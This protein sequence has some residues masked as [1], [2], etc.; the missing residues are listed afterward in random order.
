MNFNFPTK[1]YLASK[2][3][4]QQASTSPGA[5]AHWY[6]P[7][8]LRNMQKCSIVQVCGNFRTKLEGELWRTHQDN[9]GRFVADGVLLAC[10]TL[11]TIVSESYQE[12]ADCSWDGKGC[13]PT[14]FDTGVH[15]SN[16]VQGVGGI[17]LH[18]GCLHQMMHDITSIFNFL[19]ILHILSNLIRRL[20]I[21]GQK[22]EVTAGWR[23]LHSREPHSL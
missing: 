16:L 6:R 13:S 7:C 9:R 18:T 15:G 2:I 19:S 14:D 11:A 12:V 17:F 1:V 22:E 21:S 3:K 10:R 5:N 8:A 23:K 4:L 20:R